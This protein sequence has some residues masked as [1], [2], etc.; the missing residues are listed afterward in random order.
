MKPTQDYHRL[1]TTAAAKKNHQ[2]QALR[3]QNQQKTC[4]LILKTT[5][6]TQDGTINISKRVKI[7]I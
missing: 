5:G 6:K 7:I 1:I 2:N 3:A 4:I